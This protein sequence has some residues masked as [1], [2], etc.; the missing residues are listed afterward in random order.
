VIG[1]RV[2]LLCVVGMV[3]AGLAPVDA[4]SAVRSG[5]AITSIAPAA[6]HRGDTVKITG[7]GFGAQN[8]RIAVGGVPAKLLAATCNEAS[9]V[10]PASA[11]FGKTRVRATNPGGQF[12]EIAFEVDYDG[13]VTI[14][15]DDA[16]GAGADIGP[17]GGSITAG[18]LTLTVPAGALVDTVH[19]TVTPIVSLGGT[20]LDSSLI[21]GARFAPDGLRFFKPASLT[22]PLAGV[23]AD[24][25]LGFA[26]DGGGTNLHLTP[27]VVEGG[28]ITVPIAHFSSA[29]A[30]SGGTAAANAMLTY[31]PS[32]AADY[33]KHHIALDFARFG[34]NII[35]DCFLAAGFAGDHLDE[36][37][38]FGV[39]PGVHAA[40]GRDEAAFEQA[41]GEW[42]DWLSYVELYADFSACV[43]P[44]QTIGERLQAHVDEARGL[45][46]GDAVELA[47]IL[48]ARCT[49]FVDYI[50]PLRDVVRAGAVIQTLGLTIEGGTF[51]DG[52]AVPDASRLAHACAHVDIEQVTHPPVFALTQ[53]N[54]V[55]THVGIAFWDGPT[56]HDLPVEMSLS[57]TT[58][59]PA[60][61]IDGDTVS[62][63]LWETDAAQP[64]TPGLRSFQLDANPPGFSNDAD[65]GG[66]EG[67]GVEVRSRIDLQARRAGDP[68]FADST[69]PVDS[70]ASVA[71]R[72]RLAG[73]GMSGATVSLSHTGGGT[74]SLSSGQTDQQGE[75]T[76]SYTA[77]S[78]A[79]TDA[80]TA[81][82]DQGGHTF[83][84][85]LTLTIQA[86]V[87]VTVDPPVAILQPGRTAQFNAT[88]A[89]AAN[90]A[91]TWTATGGTI[92]AS[93]LYTA[94]SAPG[95]FTVTAT[96]AADPA[97]KGTAS[98]TISVLGVTKVSSFAA[99][100]AFITGVPFPEDCP[101]GSNRSPAGATDAEVTC[102]MSGATISCANAFVLANSAFHETFDGTSLIS[103]TASGDGLALVNTFF[104]NH[105][106]EADAGYSLQFTTLTP[107]RFVIDG[108]LHGLSNA[109][110]IS[111]AGTGRPF[112]V[113]LRRDGTIH[114]SILLGRG[115]YFFSVSA[116]GDDILSSSG[117]FTVSVS[118]SFTP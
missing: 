93:G 18:G 2:A 4:L 100:S 90:T 111:L 89:N 51:P 64:P 106:V 107:V 69:G 96:S 60:A 13:R 47:R 104:G 34:R 78:A 43:N 41:A 115:S 29:G 118:F 61:R 3:M 39:L 24:D 63:G 12:D 55:T 38:R 74:L 77:P 36:W 73:D 70:G 49:G 48:L 10:V 50:P 54:T 94:G 16:H 72:V 32:I 21:A 95:T 116:V 15:V 42:L 97:A 71:L 33:A 75:L 45:V 83:V 35:G 57:D 65:V 20:P 26:A 82:F 27:S 113:L 99:A 86:R 68:G 40:L 110:V 84:D 92:D 66:R 52:R 25:V 91:V 114:T 53:R 87:A 9:F 117:S 44:R 31:T 8:V 105:C 22:I 17:T 108:E 59:G 46:T 19:I 80:I 58:N 14:V 7:R 6:A 81:T 23:A 67:F 30:S 102:T 112:P 28:V 76:L 98:V 85:T 103:L 1:K 11:P 109:N 62:N 5:V 37:Y 56:R 79:G 88:V 101:V